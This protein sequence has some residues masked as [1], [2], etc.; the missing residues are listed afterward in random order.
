MKILNSKLTESL[1]EAIIEES[2]LM[3][4]VSP[5]FDACPDSEGSGF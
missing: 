1:D 5:D 4:D 3:R 2:E